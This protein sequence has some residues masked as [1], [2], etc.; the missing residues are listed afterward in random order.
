MET[1]NKELE[2]G[3]GVEK[4]HTQ[5]VALATKI[6]TDHLKADSR[7]YSKLLAAGLV[8][9]PEIVAAAAKDRAVSGQADG[10]VALTIKLPSLS[11]PT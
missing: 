7:Y 4:E 10:G 8:D 2:I 5:D 9:E 11:L 1:P 6:A 3:I